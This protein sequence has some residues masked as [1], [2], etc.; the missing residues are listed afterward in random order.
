MRS[1]GHQPWLDQELTGGQRWWDHI[2]EEIR[3][4]EV[5][6]CAVS[7]SSLDSR[8]CMAEYQYALDL[9]KPILPV[10]VGRS[11]A[12][13]LMPP[14]LAEL[15][16]VDYVS[17]DKAAFAALNR[18]LSTLPSAPPLPDPL[19]PVPPVPASY[20][21]DLK[22][23][24]GAP[25]VMAPDMQAEVVKELRARLASG[26][27][28]ADLRAL[29][30]QFRRRDDLLVRT[31]QDLAAFESSL[32]AHEAPASAPPAVAAPQP[33]VAAPTPVYREPMHPDGAD[34]SPT[35]QVAGEVHLAWWL[36]PALGGLIGG[37]V[38]YFAVRGKNADTARNMLIAGAVMSVVWAFAFA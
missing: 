11:V 23:E 38:A 28:H 33:T 36:A 30:R 8:A 26:H 3:M 21:Y 9:G 2:L 35:A 32:S 31:E 29:V 25:G 13:S 12:D 6:V 20:L 22:I 4:C 27:D 17:G 34:S 14:H 5:F 24:I 19:P 18:A 1:L 37:V 16:R 15:H 10:M 7:T